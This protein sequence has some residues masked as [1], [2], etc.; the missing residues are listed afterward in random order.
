MLETLSFRFS[1]LVKLSDAAKA[2]YQTGV[3]V[4]LCPS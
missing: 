4:S 2:E 1:V 3:L